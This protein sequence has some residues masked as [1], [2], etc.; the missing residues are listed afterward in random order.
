MRLPLIN[1]WSPKRLRDKESC[2]LQTDQSACEVNHCAWMPRN[3]LQTWLYSCARTWVT[4]KGFSARQWRT[5]NSQAKRNCIGR[6][7]TQTPIQQYQRRNYR[8]RI[9]PDKVIKG[10]WNA[11][12]LTLACQPCLHHKAITYSLGDHNRNWSDSN[13]VLNEPQHECL[14][15]NWV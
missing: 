6:R 2:N 12:D 15:M 3:H 5:F 14:V 9:D 1:E 8:I 4:V 11:S 7:P 13:H 10:K